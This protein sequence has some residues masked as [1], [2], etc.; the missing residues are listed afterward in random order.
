MYKIIFRFE[1]NGDTNM[2]HIVTCPSETHESPSQ[3][4]NSI[5]TVALFH[6]RAVSKVSKGWSYGTNSL[7][8]ISGGEGLVAPKVLVADGCLIDEKH[9]LLV[10]VKVAYSQ[11]I[12]QVLRKVEGNWM[13]APD[14]LAV[15]VIKMDEFLDYR[16]PAVDK[17]TTEPFLLQSEWLDRDWPLDDIAYDGH[18][19][20]GRLNARF[21]IF[22]KRANVPQAKTTEVCSRLTLFLRRYPDHQSSDYN[23]TSFS[24]SS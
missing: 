23:P 4:M 1:Y 11:S 24:T 18:T 9:N 13:K 6:Q 19:W 12:Q 14:V 3:W 21:L 16:G 2:L 15:I 5:F 7:F 17:A 22:I 8:C 10:V 20:Y